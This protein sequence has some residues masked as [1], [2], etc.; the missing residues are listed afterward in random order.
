MKEVMT[1]EKL[2]EKEKGTITPFEP[3]YTEAFSD[4]MRKSIQESE[5]MSREALNSASSI[6]ICR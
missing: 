5:Q 6:I 1:F 2:V 3:D 4:Y